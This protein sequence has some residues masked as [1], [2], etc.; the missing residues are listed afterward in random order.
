MSEH[1]HIIIFIDMIFF[2]HTFL[3][4][5]YSDLIDFLLVNKKYLKMSNITFSFAESLTGGL[6]MSKIT[7]KSG[8]SKYFKGGLVCYSNESKIKLLNIPQ[9]IV[10]S[11]NGVSQQVSKQM[12]INVS[13]LFD[14][15]YGIST[16]GYAELYQNNLPQVFITIY[17]SKTKQFKTIKFTYCHINYIYPNIEDKIKPIGIINQNYFINYWLSNKISTNSLIEMIY[18]NGIFILPIICELNRNDFRYIIG[19]FIKYIITDLISKEN[20]M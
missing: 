4:I 8:I 19:E 14:T 20:I 3:T 6:V 15:V 9:N 7:E 10:N 11:C 1:H 18:D 17:N 2:I 13:K 12:A 16:T 5:I